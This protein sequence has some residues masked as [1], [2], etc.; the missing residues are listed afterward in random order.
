M[1]A[2][3][4]WQTKYLFANLSLLT[5]REGDEVTSPSC[6][7]EN[8]AIDASSSSLEALIATRYM[9]RGCD[10]NTLLMANRYLFAD[11]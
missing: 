4:R 8:E 2:L 11:F 3:Y 1:G 10:G 5:S 7:T 6:A 9:Q